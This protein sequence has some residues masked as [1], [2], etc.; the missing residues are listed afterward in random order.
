[1]EDDK[2][3]WIYAITKELLALQSTG[4]LT[5]IKNINTA[6]LNL[7]LKEETYLQ[8]PPMLELLDP[9]VDRKSHFFKLKKSIYGLKQAP[10]EWFKLVKHFFGEVCLNFG[11]SDSNLFI[12][13][14]V[15]VLLFADGMLIFGEWSNADYIKNIILRKWKGKDLR[16]A[17][18]SEEQKSLRASSLK[19]IGILEITDKPETEKIADVITKQLPEDQLRKLI[20]G[21]GLA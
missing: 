19:G 13:L 2:I 12:G 8:L 20:S 9:T 1:M 5:I 11:K 15:N 10:Y 6:F 14:G 4:T 16:R 3:G 21:L 18:V 17:K 7:P